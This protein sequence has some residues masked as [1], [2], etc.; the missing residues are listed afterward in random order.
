MMHGQKQNEKLFRCV[1]V[2]RDNNRTELVKFTANEIQEDLPVFYE[3]RLAESTS[4]FVYLKFN[5]QN[6]SGV[7]AFVY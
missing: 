7:L 2:Y 4:Y 1:H 3:N 6:Y 5:Y